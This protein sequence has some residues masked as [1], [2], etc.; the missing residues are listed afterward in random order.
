MLSKAITGK[1]IRE[2]QTLHFF[3]DT[4]YTGHYFPF[5]I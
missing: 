4:A 1:K 3:V 2:I 5:K